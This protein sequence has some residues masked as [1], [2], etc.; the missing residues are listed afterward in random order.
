M[1][2]PYSPKANSMITC[3]VS[4]QVV[5]LGSIIR[6]SGSLWPVHLALAFVQVSKDEG[7]TWENLAMATIENGNYSYLWTPTAAGSYLLRTFWAG[8]M[9]HK[10]MTSLVV[11]VEVKW[12]EQ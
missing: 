5:D 1:G 8:D 2:S 11:R 7:S 9:D 10:K 4:N 6:I 3:E 12:C